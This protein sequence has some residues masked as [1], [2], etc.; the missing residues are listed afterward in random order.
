MP[1]RYDRRA[2]V[3][4]SVALR[5]ARSLLTSFTGIPSNWPA[6]L[7][8]SDHSSAIRKSTGSDILSNTGTLISGENV[9]I[10]HAVD[11]LDV[12]QGQYAKSDGLKVSL[13]GGVADSAMTVYDSATRA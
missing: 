7:S 4:W 2:T 9:T 11:T 8:V 5:P 10:Q 12:T 13:M 1:K 3:P 6:S